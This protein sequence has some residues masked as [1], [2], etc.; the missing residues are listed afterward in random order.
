MAQSQRVL[1]R[2][3][4]PLNA[5]LIFIGEAPGRLGADGT[6]IP[7]HGDKAGLNFENLLEQVGLTRNAVVVTNA[8]LC[9]PRSSLG[10]NA[11]PNRQEILNCNTH[12]K[13]QIEIIKPKI[14]VT[15]GATALRALQFIE[16][17]G[18]ELSSAVRKIFRWYNRWL[19]P[20]YHPGQR[21]MLHRSFANQLSDYQ[22]V[23]E[24]L[25]RLNSPTPRRSSTLRME[26]LAI[27]EHILLSLPQV[28][29]FGLHKLVYLSELASLKN[30]DKRLTNSYIIRQKDGPYCTDLHIAKLKRAFNG[31]VIRNTR[32]GI[33]L[34]MQNLDLFSAPVYPLNRKC[35]PILGEILE[36][37][38]RLSDRE[39][40]RIAYMSQPMR[41]ILR[42]ER[43][44]G[45]NFFNAPIFT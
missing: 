36:R 11:T 22:F 32:N 24:Q 14:V 39:L 2:A 40:K 10:T 13:T 38:G 42:A 26:V 37:Y 45:A 23:A 4:G 35:E 17:H 30:T 21:A 7:F 9:N 44:H 29:Y 33:I 5:P 18:L 8:V 6:G 20:L 41:R 43:L 3:I 28:S 16:P 34:K 31:L 27:V 1:S 15:L 19:I 12:L 25:E